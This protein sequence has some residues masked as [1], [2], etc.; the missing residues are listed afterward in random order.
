MTILLYFYTFMSLLAAENDFLLTSSNFSEGQ[1]I[2]VEHTCQGSDQSP[3][4]Q[5]TNPPVGTKSFVIIVDDPDAPD[6]KAPKVTWVHWVL[7]NIPSDVSSIHQKTTSLPKG[8]LSGYNDWNKIGYKGPCPPI[9]KHRYFHKIYAIDTVITF[10]KTPTKKEL[11]I[12]I[13][14]HILGQAQL[15]GTYQKSKPQ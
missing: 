1:P 13:D 2:P 8:G 6:P 7:F 14:G 4:L 5:W 12:S 11:L 15:I 10:D 3:Q 9:G